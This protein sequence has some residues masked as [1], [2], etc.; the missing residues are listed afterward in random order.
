MC[1]ARTITEYLHGVEY[2]GL[3]EDKRRCF[4]IPS[5]YI[6]VPAGVS[7]AQNENYNLLNIIYRPSISCVVDYVL[8]H[9]ADHR[10]GVLPAYLGL[11]HEMEE[12]GVTLYTTHK[13]NPAMSHHYPVYK[14][15]LLGEPCP[16]GVQIK[17]T[18]QV[19]LWT[20]IYLN[21]GNHPEIV[22]YGKTPTGVRRLVSRAVKLRQLS[23]EKNKEAREISYR[24]ARKVHKRKP[25]IKV[26]P[27]ES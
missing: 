27:L 23:I 3:T 7:M 4:K 20:V 14:H 13:G 15:P 12:L 9:V 18:R 22:G 21:L 11:L 10:G 16:I 5:G 6:L 26:Y 2:V 8:R 1:P 17:K 19:D 24:E 25:K